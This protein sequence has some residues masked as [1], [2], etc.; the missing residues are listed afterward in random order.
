[1]TGSDADLANGD[2]G[3]SSIDLSLRIRVS[4]FGLFTSRGRT[5]PLYRWRSMAT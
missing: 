1:M 3:Q 5:I 2:F 4:S